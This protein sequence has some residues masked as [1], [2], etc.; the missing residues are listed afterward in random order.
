VSAFGRVG[1]SGGA[2]RLLAGVLRS[3]RRPQVE[4]RGVPRVPLSVPIR[5]AT[6]EGHVGIGVLVDISERGVGLL[7]P[8]IEFDVD[9]VWIQFL[10]FD[11]HVGLRGRVAYVREVPEGLHVG[12][13]LELL[14]PDSVRFLANLVIPFARSKLIHDRKTLRSRLHPRFLWETYRLGREGERRPLPALIECGAVRAWA[15]TEDTGDRGAVLLLPH[16]LR[17]GEV[18][19]I[20]PW[21]A[22]GSQACRVVKAE[23]LELHPMVIHRNVVLYEPPT[24]P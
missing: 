4:R 7:V 8:N 16:A 18:V 23:A 21:G 12:M 9:R 24:E 20:T 19:R 13:R 10:W 3:A 14:H 11:D 2:R 1:E 15:I 17:V 6:E 22:Q 5:Y